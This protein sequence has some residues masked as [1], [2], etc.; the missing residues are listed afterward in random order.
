MLLIAMA[1]VLSDGLS[2]SVISQRLSVKSYSEAIS[3]ITIVDLG[4]IVPSIVLFLA[5]NFRSL[6]VFGLPFLIIIL[7]FLLYLP[8]AILSASFYFARHAAK[9]EN[10]VSKGNVLPILLF[11]ILTFTILGIYIPSIEKLTLIIPSFG[12]LN[13]V[14]FVI[15][16]VNLM[17]IIK[18]LAR[19]IKD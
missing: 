18:N 11:L 3:I 6:T 7:S 10:K 14:G 12:S 16:V 15:V 17:F 1:N 19:S 8:L 5:F 4:V 13:I 9:G 2:N